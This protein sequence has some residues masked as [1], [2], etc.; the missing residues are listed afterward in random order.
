[1]SNTP[2]GTY[3]P[4]YNKGVSGFGA[5][6]VVS[7]K[8]RV[9]LFYV[10]PGNGSD[11]LNDGLSGG[12]AF[13][14]IAKALSM[15]ASDVEIVL[16]PSATFN[17]V[18]NVTWT[19]GS[20]LIGAG[21]DMSTLLW[22][23]ATGDVFNL[24]GA[25]RT[26]FRDFQ[27]AAAVQKTAGSVFNLATA[28][29]NH[30]FC[31][32]LMNSPFQ[33]WTIAGSCGNVLLDE[34]T[35]Q[36]Q[37]NTWNWNYA[38]NLGGSCTGIQ[39]RRLMMGTVAS[40]TYTNGFIYLNGT[41]SSVHITDCVCDLAGIGL[42]I[43]NGQWVYVNGCEFEAGFTSNGVVI[44]G[45]NNIAIANSHFLGQVGAVISGGN[46]IDFS[47]V[48]FERCQQHGI[49]LQGGTDLEIDHCDIL[50]SG[51]ATTAT[52]DAIHVAAGVTDFTISNNR[53]GV[54]AIGN[55]NT[56]KYGVEIASGASDRYLLVNNRL[57]GWA[58]AGHIDGGSGV[59]KT[60][61]GNVEVA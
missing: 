52:Y 33:G 20:R 42:N 45:G 8:P 10:D 29:L 39:L 55:G 27:I 47:G 38:V 15:A 36:S 24:A 11:T 28:G 5:G 6:P 3:G 60:I 35:W 23:N 31:N 9:S 49:D 46:A 56:T 58:T 51:Q 19:N 48:H 2:P 25:T 30:K 1:M 50:D 4:G 53:S 54:T 7:L 12:S 37:N 34:I 57:R 61:S 14:T 41:P 44:S 32:I 21:I 26:E 59:N 16:L 43:T 13:Q 17:G 22:L 40:I 18:G